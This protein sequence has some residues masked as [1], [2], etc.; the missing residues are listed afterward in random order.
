MKRAVLVN[1]VPA[2]GKSTVARSLSD[3]TG[4]PL[5]TLDSVKESLFQELGAGDRDYNRKLSFASYISI[6]NLAGDFPDHTTVIF[7]AWFGQQSADVLRA[8]LLRSGTSVCLEL[9]CTASVDVIAQR[10]GARVGQRN[11]AHPGSEYI[12]QLRKLVVQAKPIGVC[13]VIT[14]DTSIEPNTSALLDQ[15]RTVTG[16]EKSP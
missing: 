9:W 12:P 11:T 7:D 16:F 14:L 8:H 6:F 1:G 15:I 2:S 3:A 10:Y 13:P 4:W 5:L